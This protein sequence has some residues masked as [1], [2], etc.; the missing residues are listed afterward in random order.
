MIERI[1]GVDIFEQTF[2][3]LRVTIFIGDHSDA[4]F[5]EKLVSL[6]RE[7]VGII[8]EDLLAQLSP[9]PYGVLKTGQSLKKLG[10]EKRVSARFFRQTLI[11]D[12]IKQINSI[13][14]FES[15][16]YGLESMAAIRKKLLW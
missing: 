1:R 7:P 12:I 14:F 9:E 15:A 5:L 3:H 16:G 13:E 6:I 11:D 2:V 8:I 4:K 10:N